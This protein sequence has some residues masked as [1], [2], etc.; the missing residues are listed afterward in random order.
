L[1]SFVGSGCCHDRPL[2]HPVAAARVDALKAFKLR[3][4]AR[5][6]LLAAREFDLHEVVDE[7]QAA[8]E[9]DGLI[10]AIGQDAV[11][12]LMRDALHQVRGAS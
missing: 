11:Q 2:R 10:E 6:E 7:L 8:A 1:H 5:A 3:C 12:R 4:W 9:R